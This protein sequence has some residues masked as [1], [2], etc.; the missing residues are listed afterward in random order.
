MSEDKVRRKDLC[1]MVYNCRGP[2][3]ITTAVSL[4]M[5]E[6]NISLY[7]DRCGVVK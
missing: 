7:I 3:R 1:S 4:I 5:V 2:A 6:V